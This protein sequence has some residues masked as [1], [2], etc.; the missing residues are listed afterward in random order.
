MDRIP[1]RSKAI[2]PVVLQTFSKDATSS[3]CRRFMPFCRQRKALCQW[4][5]S[6]LPT[7][8]LQGKY[9]NLAHNTIP[10]MTLSITQA[11]IP[12]ASAFRI[13]Q[14]VGAQRYM[15][16]I[17]AGNKLSM[18][19]WILSGDHSRL[20]LLGR[21]WP[22]TIEREEHTPCVLC[23]DHFWK[24]ALGSSGFLGLFDAQIFLH[25]M[26]DCLFERHATYEALKSGNSLACNQRSGQCAC[27]FHL[28]A[29]P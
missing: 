5:R 18:C 11:M 24:P 17:V 16:I 19:I 25:W 3:F 29:I 13:A 4:P 28:L 10:D 20:G 1:Y 22:T 15:S 21:E 7:P 8:D 14:R 2:I 6:F 26:S 12:R 27:P 23:A 9:M